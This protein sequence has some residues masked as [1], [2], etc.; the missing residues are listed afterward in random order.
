MVSLTMEITTTRDISRQMLRHRSFSFQ[1]FSQR[2]AEVDYSYWIARDLRLQ[3]V[4]NRQSSVETDD[5][6]A[7][8][9]WY[10]DCANIYNLAGETYEDAL[11]RGVAKEVARVLLPEGLTPTTLYMAGTLRSWYH[12]CHLRMKPETQKEHRLLAEQAWKLILE[13]FPTLKGL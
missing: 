3:D 10:D 6:E 5:K 8:L 7:A 11:R 9:A 12:Y 1:E 13:Y 2:Y 4:K